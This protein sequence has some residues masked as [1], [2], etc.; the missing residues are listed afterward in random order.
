MSYV[1]KKGRSVREGGNMAGEF[2]EDSIGKLVKASLKSGNIFID[3]YVIIPD[4]LSGVGKIVFVNLFPGVKKVD[5]VSS[6][7]HLK[8]VLRYNIGYIADDPFSSVKVL[9][10]E[11]DFSGDVSLEGIGELESFVKTNC[12]IDKIDYSVINS[13]KIS[14]NVVIKA[15]FEFCFWRREPYVVDGNYGKEAQTLKK[16][17]TVFSLVDIKEEEFAVTGRI[18]IP[19]DQDEISQVAL[20]NVKQYTG[21]IRE[22]DGRIWVKIKG[23]VEA[24]YIST[25]GKLHVESADFG[26]ERSIHVDTILDGLK[27]TMN[28]SLKDID[29]YLTEDGDGELRVLEYTTTFDALIEIYEEVQMEYLEDVYFLKSEG[30][31]EVKEIEVLKDIL[32]YKKSI[33]LQAFYEG[34]GSFHDVYVTSSF[35][36]FGA[37]EEENQIIVD[38]KV[39]IRGVLIPQEEGEFAKEIEVDMPFTNA[40]AMDDFE[41]INFENM[42][43]NLTIEEVSVSFI[44]NQKTEFDVNIRADIGMFKT[45]KIEVVCDVEQGAGIEIQDEQSAIVKLYYTS[46]NDTLWNICKKYKVKKEELQDINGDLNFDAL[47]DGAMVLIP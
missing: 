1:K 23:E 28:A 37:R 41:D 24:G 21:D 2:L 4:A 43:L 40:I 13:K 16:T 45:K 35:I 38:G 17:E 33:N 22:E 9:S 8:G 14:L 10:G 47:E 32:N 3:E 30:D 19:F 7:A 6:G 27:Y 5:Q 36:D 25:Q 39:I 34:M 11:I 26:E 18:Q 29:T 15:D 42:R 20:A 12:R 44:D 31:V 46:S